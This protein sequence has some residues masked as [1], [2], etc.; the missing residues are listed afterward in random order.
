MSDAQRHTN[1]QVH[2]YPHAQQR[3]LEE[4]EASSEEFYHSGDTTGWQEHVS[5]CA[6]NMYLTLLTVRVF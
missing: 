6:G 2:M 3:D 1:D 5:L 4:W